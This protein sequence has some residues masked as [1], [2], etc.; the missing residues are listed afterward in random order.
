MN[1]IAQGGGQVRV[2]SSRV[3]QTLTI[4]RVEISVS[5]P[6]SVTPAACSASQALPI[7]HAR[8]HC[9]AQVKVCRSVISR[10]CLRRRAQVCLRNQTKGRQAA[11]VF[12]L[13]LP[14]GSSTAQISEHVWEL[15]QASLLLVCL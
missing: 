4:A 5:Q 12:R 10:A 15:I 2:P 11:H 9:H 3:P 8:A 13:P 1:R 6:V 14:A 7:Q